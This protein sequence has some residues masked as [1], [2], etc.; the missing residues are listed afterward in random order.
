MKKFKIIF[1]IA[2]MFSIN[3]NY[4]YAI[5]N[6]VKTSQT[7]KV[8]S[9]SDDNNFNITSKNVVL[10]NLND[11]NVLYEKNASDSVSIA[12]LTKI[13]TTIVAI[14]NIKDLNKDILIKTI[15]EIL[16]NKDLYNTYHN[17]LYPFQRTGRK[18]NDGQRRG[19]GLRQTK[20]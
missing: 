2:M 7:D 9:A 4:V 17:N 15:D 12:S 10:Y 3:Y 18:G 14:E 8:T 5:D 1:L 19:K 13:M 11:N 16:D 6:K 20:Q